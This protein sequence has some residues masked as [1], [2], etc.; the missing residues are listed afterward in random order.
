LDALAVIAKDYNESSLDVNEEENE[1]QAAS[2]RINSLLLASFPW[3]TA[4]PMVPNRIA[5]NLSSD[6]HGFVNVVSLF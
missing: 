5:E 2:L 3:Y 6:H 4:L 1:D